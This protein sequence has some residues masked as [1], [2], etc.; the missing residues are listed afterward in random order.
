MT[1][2]EREE[3][4]NDFRMDELDAVMISVDKWFDEGDPQL[5]QNPASRAAYARE[6]ALQALEARQAEVNRLQKHVDEHYT[7]A[8]TAYIKELEGLV[9]DWK[10]K[11]EKY[12]AALECVYAKRLTPGPVTVA[13]AIYCFRQAAEALDK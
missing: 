8:A 4:I 9:D 7:A 11:A 2:D 6:I 5:K 13:D 3:A 12:E 10:A 1:M